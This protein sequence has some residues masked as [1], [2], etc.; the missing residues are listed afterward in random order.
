MPDTEFKL[1]RAA[2]PELD[3]PLALVTIDNGAD[4]TRPAFFG[5]S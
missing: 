3:R 2:K 4:H 5:R 1:T